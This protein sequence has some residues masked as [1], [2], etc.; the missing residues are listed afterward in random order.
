M[1]GPN[2]HEDGISLDSLYPVAND[3]DD[4]E[5]EEKEDDDKRNV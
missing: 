3:D 5:E 2:T 1:E 4:E